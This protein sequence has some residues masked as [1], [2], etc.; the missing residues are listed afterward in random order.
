MQGI[1]H[2]T[3]ERNPRNYNQKKAYAATAGV[4]AV[5][6][7]PMLIWYFYTVGQVAHAKSLYRLYRHEQPVFCYDTTSGEINYA[8][9]GDD[10]KAAEELAHYYTLVQQRQENWEGITFPIQFADYKKPHYLVTRNVARG[11]SQV[12]SFDTTCWG[13]RQEYVATWCVHPELPRASQ[14]AREEAYWKAREMDVEYQRTRRNVAH[15]HHSEYGCQ[16]D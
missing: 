14:R 5:L 16:C 8:M 2:M 1:V 15:V 3:S 6:L 7:L 13:F 10:T 9:T 12:I 4:L 11:Y